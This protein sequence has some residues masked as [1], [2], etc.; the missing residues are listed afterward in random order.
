MWSDSRLTLA[1]NV[2]V[3]LTRIFTAD[4]IPMAVHGTTHEAWN[5]IGIVIC[6]YLNWHDNQSGSKLNKEYRG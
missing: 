3:E 5:S 1:Q 4:R 2:E 6:S